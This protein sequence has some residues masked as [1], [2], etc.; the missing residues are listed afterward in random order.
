MRYHYCNQIVDP[1]SCCPLSNHNPNIPVSAGFDHP[2]CT[3][4]PSWRERMDYEPKI[5]MTAEQMLDSVRAS[6]KMYPHGGGDVVVMQEVQR[7]VKEA[8][9]KALA[10]ERAY[11]ERWV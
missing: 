8:V 1:S 11:P 7:I 5:V 6:L 2:D 4:P 9:Q 10:E 3:C